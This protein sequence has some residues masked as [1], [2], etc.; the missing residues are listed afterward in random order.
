MVI[1]THVR[2]TGGETHAHISEVR[3]WNPQSGQM[4]VSTRQT[5]VDWITG[6]SRRAHRPGGVHR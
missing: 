2:L 6:G 4:S 5:M 3:W 1:V